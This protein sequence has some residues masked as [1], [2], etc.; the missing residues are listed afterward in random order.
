[1]SDDLLGNEEELEAEEQAAGQKGGG[2]FSGLLIEI[3]KWAGIVIGAIIFIVTVV[4]VTMMIMD[5]GSASQT[6]VPQS[7]EYQTTPPMLEWYS[8]IGEVRGQTADQVRKTFIVEPWLGYDGENKQLQSELINRRILLKEEV[9]L[10]FSDKTEDELVGQQ[11]RERVKE[12]VR[13][14]LNANLSTGQIE[15][16]AFNEYT[17]VDF[18]VQV[19]ISLGV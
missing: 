1:M 6:Q 19:A 18:Y 15:T 7:Q 12:E 13:R 17:V 11:N 10:Y 2:F 4:Y 5:T 14:L 9:A 16:V 3:L 8:Q